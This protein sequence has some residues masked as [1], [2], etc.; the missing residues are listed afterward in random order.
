MCACGR[1]CT[2]VCVYICVYI[3][4]HSDT[5]RVYV[6]K[7]IKKKTEEYLVEGYD[8]KVG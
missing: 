1:V 8:I 2:Y 6:Y 4:T 5:I 3:L 7:K